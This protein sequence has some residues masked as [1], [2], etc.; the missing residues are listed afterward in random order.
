MNES[1]ITSE[2]KAITFLDRVK[3]WFATEANEAKVI[4]DDAI[5]NMEA[6]LDRRETELKA[7]PEEKLEML[8]KEIAANTNSLEDISIEIEG[9]L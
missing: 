4:K 2:H 3:S 1:D 8:Q 7:T 6:D 5:Q 9:E